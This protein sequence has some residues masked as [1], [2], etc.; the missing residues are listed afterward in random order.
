MRDKNW[1]VDIVIDEHE[2]RTRATARLHTDGRTGLVGIGTARLNPAD[3]NVP[4]IGDE[5]A[6]ARALSDLAHR[7][8]D[9]AAGDIEEVTHQPAHL[10]Y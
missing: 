9:A 2:T 6:A 8:L 10:R 4:E 7:L 3:T 1:R 5:L